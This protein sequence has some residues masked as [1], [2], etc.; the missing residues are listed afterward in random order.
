MK[1]MSNVLSLSTKT[2]EFNRTSAM[3]S[4][5][6]A[7]ALALLALI[8]LASV[9]PTHPPEDHRKASSRLTTKEA[10]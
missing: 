7:L 1:N 6:P 9:F 8:A 5:D 4:S 3:Q 10:R 2:T